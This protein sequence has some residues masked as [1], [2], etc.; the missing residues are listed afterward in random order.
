MN[1]LRGTLTALVT[2]FDKEGALDE[3][4]FRSHIQRQIAAGIEGLVPCG[5]TGEAAT[6]SVA[7]QAQVIAWCV[8]EV[9]GRCPVVAGVGSSSTAERCHVSEKCGSGRSQPFVTGD[10]T[11]Q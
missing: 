5:T 10:T 6:M 11:L 2:P 7:E 8:E 9:A 1:R 4:A 3:D